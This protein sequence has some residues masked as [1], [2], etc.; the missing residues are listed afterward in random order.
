MRDII[1]SSNDRSTLHAS[2]VVGCNGDSVV[3]EMWQMHFKQ[4][5][6]YP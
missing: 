3:T 6:N 4:L 5:Y 1:K 2:S